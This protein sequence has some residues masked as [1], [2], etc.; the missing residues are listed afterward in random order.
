M[1]LEMS[2]GGGASLDAP[3]KRGAVNLMTGLIGEGAG[4]LDA[5][6]FAAAQEALAAGFGF[7]VH[8]DALT[9]SARF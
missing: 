1:V 2:F 9:V 7:D 6:E 5:R 4:G 8:D 3:G